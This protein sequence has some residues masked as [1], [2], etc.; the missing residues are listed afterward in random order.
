[1]KCK[2][3]KSENITTKEI[4]FVSFGRQDK[5]RES[6]SKTEYI[7]KN[8]GNKGSYYE[9]VDGKEFKKLLEDM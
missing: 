9:V 1:M 3:C 4:V 8:C 5:Y 2:K 7:C 6:S